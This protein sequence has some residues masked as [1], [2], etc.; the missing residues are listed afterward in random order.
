MFET[1]PPTE[2]EPTPPQS[3]WITFNA[4]FHRGVNKWTNYNSLHPRY[5]EHVD[6]AGYVRIEADSP[7]EASKLA[8]PHFGRTCSF[9]YNTKPEQADYPLGELG[10]IDADCGLTWHDIQERG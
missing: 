10:V 1:E 7:A 3:Y 5:P 8:S 2:V 4:R 6:G 9:V